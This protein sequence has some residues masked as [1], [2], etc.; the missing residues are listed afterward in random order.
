VD[1]SG[2][3]FVAD[4]DAGAVYELLAAGDYTTVK[5]LA[6]LGAPQGLALDGSGNLFVGLTLTPPG[7]I[8]KI[9]YADPPSV[10]FPTATPVGSTDTADGT[11]TVQIQNIGNANLIGTGISVSPNWN[12]LAGSGTPEGCPASF[13]LIP[14]AECNLSIS[15]E[16]TETGSLTG[17]VTLTDNALNGADS[18]QAIPLSGT[19]ITAISPRIATVNTEYGAPYS[20]V[21]LT[22]TNF[23]TSKGSS[24]VTFNGIAAP[25]YH[26]V[27]TD[28]LT[29][30]PG[31]G[32][33]GNL[34]VTVGG[35]ASNAI[36]FTVLPMPKLTGISPTSGPVGAV[37]TISGENLLD[38]E[39]KGT[40]TFNGKSL[41]IFSQSSTALT[42]EIPTGAVTGDFHVLVNDTGMN[43][44]TFTVTP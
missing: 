10:V 41:P 43:T 34:V 22:G 32:S 27:D 37:V 44:S 33:T 13:S 40:V 5:T 36:P 28:I 14:G 9:D 23:G 7:G 2:N 42:V 38:F 24:T 19:G 30:V 11:Q 26:W 16:T 6:S 8:D 21:Y 18:T 4:P 25:V 29:T 17:A 20:V 12:L 39:N 3:V 1:A 35:K 15:F 31:N